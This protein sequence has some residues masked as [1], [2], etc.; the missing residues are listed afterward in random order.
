MP[1]DR[2]GKTP[3]TIALTIQRKSASAPPAQ[4]AV[5]ALAG[6]PG[7]AADPLGED[8]AQAIAPALSTRDLLVFDQRGT[9]HSS[10]LNCPVFNNIAALENATESTLGPLVELCALQIGPARGAFTTSESVEDIES[11]R[12]AAGYKKLVLYGTS[13]GTKVALEYAE[14]YPQHVESMVLD[15]AVPTS[16]P[17]AFGLSRFSA[18]GS[19]LNELCPTMP[20]AGSPPTRWAIWRG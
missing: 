3:G 19:A 1:L 15:S 5:L 17:E 13:Y 6:G 8:L 16:G 9:G 12:H 11:I 18:I 20:A 7:Q 10:P 2:S 14:R 4:S